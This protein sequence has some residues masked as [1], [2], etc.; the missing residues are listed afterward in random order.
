MSTSLPN[1]DAAVCSAP[2]EAR[3]HSDPGSQKASEATS[4]SAGP[5]QPHLDTASVA[6]NDF[7]SPATASGHRC[8]CKAVRNV[9]RRIRHLGDSHDTELAHLGVRSR[10][11]YLAFGQ[12][13][14]GPPSLAPTAHPLSSSW[15][16]L[17]RRLCQPGRGALPGAMHAMDTFRCY[18]ISTS[19]VVYLLSSSVTPLLTVT[20]PAAQ[21][22]EILLPQGPQP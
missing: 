11:D 17:L 5:P 18:S 3:R 14:R 21:P 6:R 22:K 9:G 4:R 2:A 8:C 19:P 15:L 7:C 13:V 10:T 20:F 1:Q 12:E 16:S